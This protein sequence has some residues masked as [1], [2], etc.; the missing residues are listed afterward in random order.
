M[1]NVGK[2]ILFLLFLTSA[3][4][5]EKVWARITFYN[6]RE[7]GGWAMAGQKG[8]NHQGYGVAAHPDFRFLTKIQI[9]ALKG[10]LDKDDEF[11]VV[12]RGSAVTKKTAAKGRGYV[13]DVFTTKTGKEFKRFVK[14]M[15]EW[16]WVIIK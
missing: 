14:S 9:P 7:S 16:G 8:K 13:F 4:A 11:I 12:D 2:V 6:P 5:E 15:P 3:A 10:V 1:M